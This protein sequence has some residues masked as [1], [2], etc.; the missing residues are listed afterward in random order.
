MMAVKRMAGDSVVQS[1]NGQGAIGPSAQ[2]S[3]PS[4]AAVSLA[5]ASFAADGNAPFGELAAIA[6]DALRIWPPL[7]LQSIFGPPQTWLPP[8][9]RFSEY[10][11]LNPWRPLRMFKF[12]QNTWLPSIPRT[13]P[14]FNPPFLDDLFWQPTVI[15]QRPDHYGSYTSYPDEAWFLINGIMTNDAVAQ[16]N[17]ALVAE[18]F[19]RPV[20]LIQNSTSSLL[21]DLLQCSLDKMNWRVTEPVIKA[22]PAIYDALVSPYKQR[23]VVIAHSQGTIIAAVLLR[24]LNQITQR[25]QP[26]HAQM[27]GA[28]VAAAAYAP[29]EFIFPDGAPL[30]AADFAPLEESQL[31]KLELYSFATCANVVT[32]FRPPQADRPGLPHIEHFG[33]EFDIVARLGM[34]APDAH[35][36]RIQIQGP[37]YVRPG[38]WGHLL[39]AHYLYPI[40]DAQRH[41]RR[42]GGAGTAAPFVAIGQTG[43]EVGWAAESTPRLFRYINGGA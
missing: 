6:G 43:S 33:N 40:A 13:P 25:E 4:A 38:A 3:G 31:A 21:T 7:Y 26:L 32:Y 8:Y 11:L 10:S 36:R 16:I 2:N 37:R 19:H 23:V 22:F 29:P 39:N 15:L 20:T 24:L 14:L 34:Q 1:V 35:T 41:G 18:L 12:L 27:A 30:D 5:A 28:P 42:R 17:A 9:R